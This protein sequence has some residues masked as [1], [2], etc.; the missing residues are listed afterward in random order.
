VFS[1]T[2]SATDH[3]G[4][5]RSASISLD[6]WAG[7]TIRIRFQAVDGGANNLVEVEVDDVRVTR[8]S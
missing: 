3:D 6:A 1:R 4:L 5:W 7:S 2:G 8:P